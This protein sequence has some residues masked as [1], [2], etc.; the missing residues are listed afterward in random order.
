MGRGKLGFLELCLFND[1]FSGDQNMT[2]PA[3]PSV[4][5]EVVQAL[6]GEAKGD[7]LL[8][9]TGPSPLA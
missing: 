3:H 9:L 8:S 5:R 1:T 2:L 7:I 4:I 6:A